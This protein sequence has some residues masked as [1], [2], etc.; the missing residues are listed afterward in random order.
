[1]VAGML[2][3][4]LG[5]CSDKNADPKTPAASSAAIAPTATRAAPA[6]SAASLRSEAFARIVNKDLAAAKAL[7][8]R[9]RD[10]EPGN[11][12]V[13]NNLALLLALE[14]RVDEARQMLKEALAATQ[15]ADAAK[16][17]DL[18][19]AL[20]PPEK[21]ALRAIVSFMQQE[22]DPPQAAA[23]AA[24]AADGNANIVMAHGDSTFRR[25]R[26]GQG[27]A[28]AG[29]LVGALI[30]GNAQALPAP[31]APGMPCDD[32]LWPGTALGLSHE[33][34]A[35][36]EVRLSKGMPYAEPGRRYVGLVLRVK[37]HPELG[38]TL[39]INA[40]NACGVTD[41]GTAAGVTL[42]RPIQ[43]DRGQFGG[44]N[45]T[46]GLM[47][48]LIQAVGPQ[49]D[50]KWPN[51][52]AQATGQFGQFAVRLEPGG[53]ATFALAFQVRTGALAKVRVVGREYEI[54]P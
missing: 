14:G 49:R 17:H 35:S 12:I 25:F 40:D 1:M 5:G 37:A 33:A 20:A 23:Q 51:Y 29:A 11:A 21:S 8:Q 31:T 30:S 34:L 28:M 7:L 16:A 27:N 19:F 22:G 32:A 24:S 10:A 36:G 54:G 13:L 39:W 42:V 18:A 47:Y 38:A 53:S 44:S 6:P 4:L 3:V 43:V 26:L 9:A 46:G 41:G 2:A 45:L 15:R 48:G 50:D 52:P